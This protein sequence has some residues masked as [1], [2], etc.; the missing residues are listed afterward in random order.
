MSIVPL[1]HKDVSSCCPDRVQNLSRLV[2]A[3]PI[4]QRG[5]TI[6][7][8]LDRPRVHGQ[9]PAIGFDRLLEAPRLVQLERVPQSHVG[10][11]RFPADVFSSCLGARRAIPHGFLLPPS[12]WVTVR[13]SR[14]CVVGHDVSLASDAP[15]IQ[16]RRIDGGK[17]GSGYPLPSV[18]PSRHVCFAPS[19]DIPVPMSAFAMI[20]SALAP[21]TAIPVV[22]ADFRL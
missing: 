8:G 11:S 4:Q 1:V 2:R 6:G 7:P 22:V 15:R 13:R 9:N 20:S 18:P 10:L 3:L 12:I 17:S 5:A 19:P 16:A 14:P 21:K